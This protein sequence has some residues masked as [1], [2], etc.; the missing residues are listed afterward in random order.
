MLCQGHLHVSRITVLRP[1][2]LSEQLMGEMECLALGVCSLVF[3]WLSNKY[4]K[5][6]VGE[7]K[8]TVLLPI[9]GSDRE[10]LPC[11]SPAFRCLPAIL[12][13]HWL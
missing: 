12:D 11:F 1:S 5:I 7:K 4:V 10:A 13:V 6:F 3:L 2:L 9:R 8:G